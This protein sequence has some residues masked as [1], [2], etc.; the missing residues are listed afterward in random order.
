MFRLVPALLLT[1]ALMGAEPS[2][3]ADVRPILSENCFS[4]HG[5]DTANNK[6]DLRL[7]RPDDA[8]RVH[9]KSGVRAIVPGDPS[10]SEAWRRILSRDPDEMMPPPES[11]ING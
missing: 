1:P 8:I 10:A 2:F 11:H 4:C 9:P 5:P 7:D 6:A 3:N